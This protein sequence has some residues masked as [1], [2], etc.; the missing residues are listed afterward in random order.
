MHSQP[1]FY[2]IAVPSLLLLLSPEIS[3][4]IQASTHQQEDKE[5]NENRD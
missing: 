3:Y 4:T 5:E 2:I 1:F